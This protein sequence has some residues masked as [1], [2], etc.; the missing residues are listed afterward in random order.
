ML[1]IFLLL[2]SHLPQIDNVYIGVHGPFTFAVDTGGESTLVDAQ[3]A[4]ALRLRPAFRVELVTQAGQSLAPGALTPLTVAGH[5]IPDVEVLFL[6]LPGQHGI[7]GQSALRHLDYTIDVRRGTVHLG[8]LPD[9]TAYPISLP[10]RYRLDHI[11]V[12]AQAG[13]RELVLALDSGTDTLLLPPGTPGLRL[14]AEA[15]LA[16]HTGQ[17][18]VRSGKLKHL[19]IGGREWR[20]LPAATL[21]HP[22]PAAAGL[23][24]AN[25]FTAIHVSNSTGRLYLR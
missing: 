19:G 1:P 20:D 16:S 7:L 9:P 15:L 5:A 8:P 2:A 11:L 4:A 17:V 12:P 10:L 22:H 21:P 25:A 23:L 6:P 18:R 24:P 13:G 3:L 14:N